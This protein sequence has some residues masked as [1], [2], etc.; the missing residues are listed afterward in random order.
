MTQ[1]RKGQY[2]RPEIRT[3]LRDANPTTFEI[4][5]EPDAH[6][7]H[8]NERA[9]DIAVDEL[10]KMYRDYEKRGQLHELDFQVR[11]FCELLKRRHGGKLPP[12]KGGRPSN[13]HQK[14]LIAVKVAEA[15][16]AQ[17]GKRKNVTRAIQLVHDT[18]TIS[19]KRCHVPVA[20][21]RD[22]YYDPDPEWQRTVKV[23]LAWRKLK[24]GM[25]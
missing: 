25:L 6:K 15:V 10:V 19:N 18:L 14:L 2:C 3:L 22:I 1:R 17:A 8:R 16:A 13:E 11:I 12:G 24:P 7:R 23:E 21:I 20:T 5:G 9:R 4:K